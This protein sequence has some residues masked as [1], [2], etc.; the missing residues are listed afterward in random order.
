MDLNRPRMRV[1][2]PLGKRENWMLISAYK[3]CG[4]KNAIVYKGESQYLKEQT[5]F[6][7]KHNKILSLKLEQGKESEVIAT[8]QPKAARNENAMSNKS[9]TGRPGATIRSRA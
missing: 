4:G 6:R 3:G 8:L 9:G 2:V 7:C 1:A 5:P